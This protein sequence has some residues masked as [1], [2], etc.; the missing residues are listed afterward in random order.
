MR[1]QWK[2]NAVVAVMAV[3]VCSAVALNW[4]YTGQEVQEASGSESDQNRVGIYPEFY[5]WEPALADPTKPGILNPKSASGELA[6]ADG[7]RKRNKRIL[8]RRRYA[9]RRDNN[10]RHEQCRRHNRMDERKR[11]DNGRCGQLRLDVCSR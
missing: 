11:H 5:D 8:L 10:C 7:N 6:N 9:K 4:L 3:L 1:N 2:R